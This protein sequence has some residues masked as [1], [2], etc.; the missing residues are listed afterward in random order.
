MKKLDAQLTISRPQYGDGRK[1]IVIRLDDV[2][3]SCGIVDIYIKP[4]DFAECLTGLSM[5]PCTTEVDLDRPIGKK[6]E[7]KREIVSR[8]EFDRKNLKAAA[9]LLAPYEIDGWKG[10]LSDLFNSHRWV[11]AEDG[12][13]GVSVQFVRHVESQGS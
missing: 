12:Q 7:H 8:P 13:W 9:Q 6:R 2:L 1:M 4:E 11:L 10:D 3:S 5:V